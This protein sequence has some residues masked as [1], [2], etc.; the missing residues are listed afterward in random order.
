[1]APFSM[2]SAI[3]S[4]SDNVTAFGVADAPR[5]EV[6]P[7][8]RDLNARAHLGGQDSRLERLTIED[9]LCDND[10][11]ILNDKREITYLSKTNGTTSAPLTSRPLTANSKS[12]DMEDS[13][14]CY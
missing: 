5:V 13:K 7:M 9:L 2:N 3:L 14:K 8:A 1:M 10:L 6:G 4:D 12:S 11:S